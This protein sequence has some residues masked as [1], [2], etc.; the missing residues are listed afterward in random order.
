MGKVG[1][2]RQPRSGQGRRV[3]TPLSRRREVWPNK[4]KGSLFCGD[5]ARSRVL[6]E[7]A[8]AAFW[9]FLRSTIGL[10]VQ[11]A[12]SGF[13]LFGFCVE[14]LVGMMLFFKGPRTI[15]GYGS[16]LRYSPVAL[17]D[18]PLG[19]AHGGDLAY[20]DGH[21]PGFAP[22]VGAAGRLPAEAVANLLVCRSHHEVF[23]SVRAH[24]RAL[25][26][27]A[28]HLGS[29]RDARELRRGRRLREYR[30]QLPIRMGGAGLC[31][32]NV[33]AW[34]APSARRS[35]HV[36]V[37]R[38]AASSLRWADSRVVGGAT[39]RLSR[40]SCF[41]PAPFSSSWLGASHHGTEIQRAVRPARHRLVSAQVRDEAG[42]PS[43]QAEVQPDRRRI[44]TGGRF[45]GGVAGRAGLRR[46]LLLLPGQ[47][48]AGAQHRGAG[49]NQRR[50]ELS[51][52][53]RQRVPT[54]LRH[55]QGRGL[56]GARTQ[57]VPLAEVSANIIDQCVAQGVP[58]AREYGGYLANRSFGGA[59]VSRTF[60]ARGQTG[61]QLLL[62]A[63]QALERQIAAGKVRM[64]PRTEM[65]DLVIVD[66]KA[67]GIVTRDMV[68]GN[69]RV[70]CGGRRDPGHRWL[71]QCVLPFHQCQGLQR[72]GLVACAQTRGWFRQSLFHP[73]SSYLHSRSA[74]STNRSSP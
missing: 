15:N 29:E 34:S 27:G 61:Q 65:L 57:R 2:R 16:L 4:T 49:R 19:D 17:V 21:G 14:H 23:R 40:D 5:G 33:S 46:S 42:Q 71:W 47:S 22:V 55:H 35:Q 28:F 41:F 50:E 3:A 20:L 12:V 32:G 31:R 63:Y 60:Y 54:V 73:D 64:F 8:M 66:G 11:M 24:L 59:Q 7:N 10:K 58:F 37:A 36:R 9:S 44:R 30:E 53:R 45:R 25:P 38:S 48:R 56:P 13:I 72:H 6:R 52:R 51:E 74:A 69:D 68:S 1:P 62:G 70:A 67:R 26:S 18:G 39:L 43:Q